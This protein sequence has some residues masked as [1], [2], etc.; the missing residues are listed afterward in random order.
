MESKEQ[1]KIKIRYHHIDSLYNFVHHREKFLEDLVEK[2]YKEGE[3][4]NV[5]NT[6]DWILSRPSNTPIKVKVTGFEDIVCSGCTRKEDESRGSYQCFTQD[7]E[8]DTRKMFSIKFSDIMNIRMGKSY[9]ISEILRRMEE[10]HRIK[11]FIHEEISKEI[12]LSAAELRKRLFEKGI[13][14]RRREAANIEQ[15]TIYE[16]HQN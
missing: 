14:K 13:L 12:W 7:E 1:S 8:G 10:Y 11:D 6:F 5:V 2:N 15:K 16:N 3:I 9:R 4:K